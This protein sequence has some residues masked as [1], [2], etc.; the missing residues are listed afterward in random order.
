MFSKKDLNSNEIE[1]KTL[2]DSSGKQSETFVE[3][4]EEY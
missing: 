3:D 1:P 2:V 4:A